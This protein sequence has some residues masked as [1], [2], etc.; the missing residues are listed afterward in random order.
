MARLFNEQFS[1]ETN[2]VY[3][4]HSLLNLTK[5]VY[6]NKTGDVMM[7]G[8]LSMCNMNVDQGSG[9]ENNPASLKKK[10]MDENTLFLP[11]FSSQVLVFPPSPKRQKK[12]Q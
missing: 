6:S 2:C 4:D 3:F 12:S 5:C 1:E 10:L 11:F 7:Q 8:S 9:M